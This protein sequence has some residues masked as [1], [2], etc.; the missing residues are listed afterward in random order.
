[1]TASKK[2]GSAGRKLRKE[3]ETAQ[4]LEADRIIKSLDEEN[5]K[6][7]ETINALSKYTDIE[8]KFTNGRRKA[9][10]TESD[11]KNKYSRLEVES[12]REQIRAIQALGR[13]RSAYNKA[14]ANL[15]MDNIINEEL[16]IEVERQNALKRLELLDSELVSEEQYLMAKDALNSYY[17]NL[18]L[19][20]QKR[21]F[22]TTRQMRL[23]MF[24]YMADS[25]GSIGDLMEK[26]SKQAK[27]FALAEIVANTA[28]GFAQGLIVAQDQS[29][30]GLAMAF[31]LFYASQIAAVLAAA[32]RAKSVLDTGNVN[33]GGGARGVG[34]AGGGLQ[35]PEFNVVG[36]SA[37]NQLAMAVGDSGL[38]QPIRAYV[39]GKDITN[40]Q[41]FD[42]NQTNIA[43]T[44]GGRR[45]GN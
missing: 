39:V 4:V 25:L 41:E 27:T 5:I 42:N 44:G 32:S 13:A 43:G 37:T 18:E 10:K 35:A 38:G 15:V 33:A 3:T 34:Q 2:R 24:G 31:P 9:S 14:N 26:N 1:L 12:F 29:K 11:E 20:R 21:N 40:Q 6:R 36:A 28:I 23:D 30:G 22:E 19:D 17:D 7:R 8:L 16:R 45:T